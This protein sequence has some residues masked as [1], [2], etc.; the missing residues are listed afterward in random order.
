MKEDFLH[1]VWK[2]QKFITQDL[3]AIRGEVI[4]IISPG[5]HNL[6]TGPDFF[7]AQLRIDG[8][9]WAG[10][11]EIHIKSSD[12]YA[13]HHERD[14]AYDS[15][16]LHVVWEYDAAIFRNDNSELPTL[17]LKNLVQSDAQTSYQQLFFSE[18]RW[19]AC[20]LHFPK[21]EPF[22]VKHWLGSLF[23]ERLEQKNERLLQQL[24]I[25]KYHW[26]ALFFVTL[27]ANFGLKVNG[28][29]F[30]SI[31]ESVDFSIITKYAQQALALECLLFGQAG[32][33]DGANEDPH[34]QELKERYAFIKNKHSLSTKGVIMPK[35]FR[36]R[37]PNFPTIRLSQFAALWSQHPHLFSKMIEADSRQALHALFKASASDYW[38]KHYNFGVV[39][40]CRKKTIT[41]AFIDLLLIN[42][43]IPIKFCYAKFQGKDISEALIELAESIPKEKNA[44]VSRFDTL[45]PIA[46]NAFD[47]QGLLQLKNNYCSKNRCMHCAIGIQYLKE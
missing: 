41:S 16:I 40:V 23:F 22:L 34:F 9:Q 7:N 43:V 47:S 28:E 38:D 25:S 35:Y 19:I 46:Q 8:Q 33:L 32:L 36:L 6:N 29:A 21:I 45:Q 30:K 4:E 31:A 2:F 5:Q 14:P 3:Q 12:W 27:G 24:E 42:T 26:D 11:V 10:N 39:S 44:I 20:E 18:E 1:Y 37:P 15:V 13:H 17:V